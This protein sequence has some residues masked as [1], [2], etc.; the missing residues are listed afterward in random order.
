MGLAAAGPR[1]SASF[2]SAASGLRPPTGTPATTAA[3]GTLSP[4][5]A[6][7]IPYSAPTTTSNAPAPIVRATPGL[8]RRPGGLGL[9]AG[10]A[11]TQV[12]SCSGVWVLTNRPYGAIGSKYEPR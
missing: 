5:M 8:S 6:Y 11:T 12:S 10:V 1:A 7:P 2:A 3:F 4:A 9:G